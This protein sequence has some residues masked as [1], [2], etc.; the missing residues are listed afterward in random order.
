MCNCLIC[1]AVARQRS[2]SAAF[3]SSDCLRFGTVCGTNPS[4][5]ERT[6][7][8]VRQLRETKS[9]ETDVFKAHRLLYDST[10]DSRVIK[11][12][13]EDLV[14]LFRKLDLVLVFVH[15]RLHVDALCRVLFA[16]LVSGFRFTPPCVVRVRGVRFVHHINRFTYAVQ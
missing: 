3:G 6:R 13:K 14:E 12:K 8:Q 10:L 9:T 7:A 4:A 16:Q 2:S 1:A 11:K 15:V 5:L